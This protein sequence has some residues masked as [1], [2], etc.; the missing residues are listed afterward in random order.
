M[1]TYEYIIR[2]DSGDS[3]RSPV[4]K[5]SA[6]KGNAK[7][8]EEQGLSAKQ[9]YN[10][11]RNAYVVK[12]TVSI[13]R[14]EIN[15]KANTV[16]LRTGAKDLQQKVD[17]TMGIAEKGLSVIGAAVGGFFVGGAAG[18]A[19]AAAVTLLSQIIGTVQSISQAQRTIDLK[20]AI[21]DETIRMNALR[22]GTRGSRGRYE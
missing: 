21:E 13:L 12:E 22:A 15:Y 19:G 5:V 9:V 2:N 14:S 16:E 6:N 3:A 8:S 20:Q 10:K 7:P 11:F 4:A 1:A 18:A 17:F